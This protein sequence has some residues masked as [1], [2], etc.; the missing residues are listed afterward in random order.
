MFFYVGLLLLPV[1]FPAIATISQAFS[2]KR[3]AAIAIA[4]VAATAWIASYAFKAGLTMPNWPHTWHKTGVGAG[5]RGISAPEMFL[6]TVT[7]LSVL[8]GVLLVI[9]LFLG[10]I[11]IARRNPGAI[12]AYVFALMGAAGLAGILCLITFKWDRYLLPIVPWLVLAVALSMSSARHTVPRWSLAVGGIIVL[13]TAWY[14]IVSGHNYT[15]ERR[16]W[17]TAI[18][19]LVAQGVPRATID[20][21][22][23][24][25]GEEL[26]GYGRSGQKT[27]RFMRWYT[28]RDY[29]IGANSRPRVGSVSH[30]PSFEL[31]RK[32]DVPRWRFW[33]RRK[34]QPLLVFRA[35]SLSPN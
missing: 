30:D 10:A 17:A 2:P 12:W 4:A 13:G 16:V 22:W 32:Y 3:A 28:R 31:Y 6:E 25:D 8:G 24:F 15:A 11:L 14:S 9:C 23:I 35:R 19:D 18:H 26:F 7:V 20:G 27:A 29:V 1:T 21:T 34:G 33:G 5:S